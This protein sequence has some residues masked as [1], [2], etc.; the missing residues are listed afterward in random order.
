MHQSHPC[1]SLSLGAF[2]HLP[3]IIW[4]FSSNGW[5]G[6]FVGSIFPFPINWRPKFLPPKKKPQQQQQQKKKHDHRCRHHHHHLLLFFQLLLW[7]KNILLLIPRNLADGR[8]TVSA[9]SYG[10]WKFLLV[11]GET[12]VVWGP[13]EIFKNRM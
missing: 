7:L 4:L 11:V 12:W 2:W 5:F 13:L 3:F 9:F 8:M 6:L 1:R 10:P